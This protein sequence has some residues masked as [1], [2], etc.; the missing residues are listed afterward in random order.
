MRPLVRQ[1]AAWMFV[2]VLLAV[3]AAAQ[4]LSPAAP[5]APPPAPINWMTVTPQQPAQTVK[6]KKSVPGH[7]FWV[8]PAYQVE[9][10]KQVP[11]LTAHEKFQEVVE[12]TYDPVGLSMGVVEVV[13]LE[14]D[15]QGGFCDYGHG[16]GGFGKCYGGA[17]L[18]A[19]ISGFLGDYALPAW[20]HQDP[21][22]F[23]LGTGPVWSRVLYSFSRVVI[24]RSDDG[25]TVFDSSQ[26]GGTFAAGAISNL[27]Y[28]H[29]D[30]GLSLTMSRIGI[31]LLGTSIFNLEA[32]F[33]PDIHRLV[34]H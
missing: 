22:Y 14:H 3:T 9:Y 24:C 6:P 23:R 19:N 12:D 17:L 16:W 4:V 18:D 32:E 10:L 1:L 27:Y 31:D 7:I 21:R 29:Q 11:P 13:L 8:I 15:P 25:K 5:A 28:P 30:R 33:W 26:L 34:F 2:P 20:W